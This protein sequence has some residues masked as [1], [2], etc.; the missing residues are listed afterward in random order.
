[1]T[2]AEIETLVRDYT[3]AQKLVWLDRG[4]WGDETDGHVDNAACFIEPGLVLMQA[5]AEGSPDSARFAENLR[6][7]GAA[8][9]A[10]GRNLR[11]ARI[12]E[13]PRR[14]CRGEALTLSYVNYYPVRGGLIV[15]VFGKDG[16]SDLRR[17]DDRAL[18]VLADLYPGRKIVS[19][20]G[21]KI[22]QGGGNVHC[23]TQQIPA[24]LVRD[25]QGM[26][27]QGGRP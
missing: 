12:D 18:G 10:R 6:R 26:Y 3:G 1:L 16:S 5:A 21:M 20:D 13:P 2:K 22:I 14:E 8:R 7:L 19:V 25:A 15:P 11:V 4:L 9:D 24:P 23:I 27:S 17:A